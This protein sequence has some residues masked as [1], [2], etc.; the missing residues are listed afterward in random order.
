MYPKKHKIKIKQK[1]E[2]HST[3]SFRQTTT[4]NNQQYACFSISVLRVK[5]KKKIKNIHQQNV[6]P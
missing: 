5:H 2:S 1:T 3:T 4:D 6:P